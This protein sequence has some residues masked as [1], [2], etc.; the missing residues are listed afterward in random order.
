LTNDIADAKARLTDYESTNVAGD[1]GSYGQLIHNKK[2]TLLS[3]Q[4]AYQGSLST[5]KALLS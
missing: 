5:A 4:K 1:V 3:Q 2:V